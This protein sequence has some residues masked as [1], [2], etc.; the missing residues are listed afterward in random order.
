MHPPPPVHTDGTVSLFCMQIVHHVVGQDHKSHNMILSASCVCV[1]ESPHAS[2][3]SFCVRRN[4][5][6]MHAIMC[7]RF[8]D[9]RPTRGCLY[10]KY[11]PCGNQHFREIATPDWVGTLCSPNEEFARVEKYVG[12][13]LLQALFILPSTLFGLKVMESDYK[14][15]CP[16]ILRRSKI[17]VWGA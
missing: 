15:H 12:K 16:H 4:H 7:R 8:S 14:M 17:F 10:C 9:F 1:F 5:N 11:H 3:L 2:I 13:T 6:M